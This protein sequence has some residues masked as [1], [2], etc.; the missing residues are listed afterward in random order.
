MGLRC[1][2][3]HGTPS[4]ILITKN[5]TP[6]CLLFTRA[7]QNQKRCL[8]TEIK[9]AGFLKTS[10]PLPQ[11]LVEALSHPQNL[12]KDEP[13][14]LH[15][16]KLVAW[17]WAAAK[18]VGQRISVFFS[19]VGLCNLVFDRMYICSRMYSAYDSAMCLL[20]RPWIRAKMHLR[21]KKKKTSF[22]MRRKTPHCYTGKM[23]RKPA[24]W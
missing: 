15:I 8:S 16:P 18:N 19:S 12:L 14:A 9:P 21:K 11:K 7:K 22:G 20:W 13:R 23:R 4:I 24:S 6:A 1:K 17:C 5:I 3:K 2:Q 10:R